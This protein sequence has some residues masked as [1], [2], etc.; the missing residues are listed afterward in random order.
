MSQTIK[1]S[2]ERVRANDDAWQNTFTAGRYESHSVKLSDDVAVRP[3]FEDGPSW[4][5]ASRLSL[6]DANTLGPTGTLSQSTADVAAWFLR[7]SIE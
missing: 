2:D 5:S 4:V 3:L 7:S 6:I 1:K